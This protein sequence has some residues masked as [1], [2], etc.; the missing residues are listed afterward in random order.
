MEMPRTRVKRCR[1]LPVAVVRLVSVGLAA[2]S[3]LFVPGL[4]GPGYPA[5]LRQ[6]GGGARAYGAGARAALR[7]LRRLRHSTASKMAS[8]TTATAAAPTMYNKVL[9][10]AVVGTLTSPP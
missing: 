9:L 1:F 4:L 3:P 7:R 10:G 5:P 2:L 8:R 6:Y